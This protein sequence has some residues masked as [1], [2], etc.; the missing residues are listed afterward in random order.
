[1]DIVRATALSKALARAGFLGLGG[2][3]PQ[4]EDGVPDA[5]SVSPARTLLVIGSAGPAL[6]QLFEK[7]PEAADGLSDPLD[8]Y[9]ARVLRKVSE[10]FGFRVVFPFDGPPW[11]PFQQWAMKA[12]GFSPSPMGVLAHETYGPWAGFRAAFLSPEVFGTFELNGKP[13]P[14]ETCED[15]P[16]LSACP[17][18]ALSVE[19]GYDVPR[20]RDHLAKKPE[21]DCF[22]GC[23][24]RRA[25]PYG[26]EF[27][28]SPGQAKF[29]MIAFL[30]GIV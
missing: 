24:A 2:F 29:H 7:S 13:G 12:G 11:H 20:C 18:G 8:R 1:M 16:C 9:T 17:A 14:C 30:N 4:P 22:S 5:A 26:R 15:K 10:D 23:L 28:Q 19:T 6:F 25:C 27:L 21:A 3:H